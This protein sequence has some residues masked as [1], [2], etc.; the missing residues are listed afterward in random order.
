MKAIKPEDHNLRQN[1]EK[2]GFFYKA[3]KRDSY[4]P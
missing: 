1:S 2:N 3:G 4:F